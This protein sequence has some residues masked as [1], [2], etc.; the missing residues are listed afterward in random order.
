MIPRN[1]RIKGN[2]MNSDGEW[3]AFWRVEG[4]ALSMPGRGGGGFQPRKRRSDALQAQPRKRRSASLQA[5]PRKRRS[6]SLQAKPRK[7]R[8]ASLQAQPRKRRS[9]SLQAKPRSDGALPSR[10]SHGSD[11]AL[12]SRPSRGSDRALPSRRVASAAMENAA[13]GICRYWGISAAEG[14]NCA[15]RAR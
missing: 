9:A 2:S 5:Q 14:E 1:G 4:I 10:P 13:C 11:G 3:R 8:S 7:R 12:P 15:A 6:A